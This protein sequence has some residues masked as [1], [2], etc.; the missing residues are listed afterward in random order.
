MNLRLLIA[1]TCLAVLLLTAPNGYGQGRYEPAYPTFP[2]A[3][4]YLRR[5]TGVLNTYYGLVQPSRQLE[6]AQQRFRDS[7]LQQQ[8]A[9]NN[10]Q[11]QVTEV[12][13]AQVGPTGKRAGF[14][15][16]SHYYGGLSPGRTQSRP[17]NRAR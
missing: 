16:Y 15:N 1:G 8:A 9:I 12:R 6:S 3:F 10:L 5:D 14:M 17:N 13:E 2:P 4:N 7:A 11:R